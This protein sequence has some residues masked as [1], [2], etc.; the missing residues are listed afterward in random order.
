MKDPWVKTVTKLRQK[1]KIIDLFAVAPPCD[2]EKTEGF[3]LLGPYFS[4]HAHCVCRRKLSALHQGGYEQFSKDSEGFKK[5]LM[6]SFSCK[7]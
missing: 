7:T 6:S 5:A 2:G 4:G 1:L 3:L